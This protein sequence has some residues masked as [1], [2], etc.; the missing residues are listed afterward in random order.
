MNPLKPAAN[1]LS[2]P[3]E[4]AATPVGAS[5][6]PRST[7]RRLALLGS[8]ALAGA[9]TGCG[10]GLYLT[11][12]IGGYD[13]RPPAVAISPLPSFVQPG[14]V[15]T[16]GAAASSDWGISEVAFYRI[17]GR[18]ATFLGADAFPPYQ[19]STTIPGDG[20]GEVAYF[21]RATDGAGRVGDSAVVAAPIAY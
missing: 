20:R 6:R 17:D 19:W 8:L 21:A 12:P 7:R 5:R 13:D 3:P 10:G 15:L 2:H 1:D 18:F 4:A 16:L 11:V 9:L 14:G